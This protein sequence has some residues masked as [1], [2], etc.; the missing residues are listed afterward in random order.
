MSGL[1]KV[2]KSRFIAC[3]LA[4]TFGWLGIHRFF[5]RE[6]GIGLMY[7][8]FFWTGLPL[9]LSWLDGFALMTESID[10]LVEDHPAL[11]KAA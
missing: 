3:T 9:V 1:A 4:F 10:D 8:V 7:L 6:Y 5:L 2:Q 11:L